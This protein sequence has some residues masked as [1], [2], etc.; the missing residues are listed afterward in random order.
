MTKFKIKTKDSILFMSR[1]F[2]LEADSK[3]AALEQV[4]KDYP[5]SHVIAISEEE[6]SNEH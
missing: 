5:N 1:V 6:P 2:V 4:K 3:E